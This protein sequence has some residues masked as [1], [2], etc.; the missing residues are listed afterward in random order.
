MQCALIWGCSIRQKIDDGL[1][2]FYFAVVVLSPNFFERPLTQYKLEAVVQRD[3]SGAG[4]LLPIWHRLMQ[5]DVARHA[6]LTRRTTGTS[7]L[8]HSTDQFVS[9]LL[10]MRDRFKAVT[11]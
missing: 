2:C 3:L 7:Y 4:R 1:R 5:G 8:T 10:T 9:E 11:R 6:P